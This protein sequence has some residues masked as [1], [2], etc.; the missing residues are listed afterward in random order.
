MS[1]TKWLRE[2]NTIYALMHDGWRK[3]EELFRNRFWAHFYADKDC[4]ADELESVVRAAHAAPDL[5]EACKAQELAERIN[6]E[7]GECEG[8]GDW[9]ECETCSEYFGK[10]IDLRR[11]AI[12]KAER[13][14]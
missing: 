1:E 9:A 10:A 7:C 13:A 5:L 14:K 4:P 6:E 11:A 8:D 3:G 12:A 2:G